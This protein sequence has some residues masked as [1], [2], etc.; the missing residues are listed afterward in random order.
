MQKN[1]V[2]PFTLYY[3]QKLTQNESKINLNLARKAE[4]NMN[5]HVFQCY[6][7]RHVLKWNKQKA[8]LDFWMVRHNSIK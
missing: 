6:I 4:I 7:E 5:N 1:E 8:I 3:M 2:G